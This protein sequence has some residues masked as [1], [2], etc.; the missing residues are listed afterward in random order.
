MIVNDAKA[1]PM[2]TSIHPRSRNY[3]DRMRRMAAAKE[4]YDN[5]TKKE[6]VGMFYPTNVPVNKKG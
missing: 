4:R 3:A 2:Q 1:K 6:R 5:A